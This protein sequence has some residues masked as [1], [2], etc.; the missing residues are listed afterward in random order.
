VKIK[1]ET[2]NPKEELQKIEE[3]RLKGRK[4]YDEKNKEIEK[5]LLLYGSVLHNSIS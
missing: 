4:R 1:Q 3:A 5:I 2:K